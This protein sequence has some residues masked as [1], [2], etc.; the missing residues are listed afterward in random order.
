M[1]TPVLPKPTSTPP[2]AID[3][4]IEYFT[5]RGLCQECYHPVHSVGM[6]R[7]SWIHTLT[8]NYTCPPGTAGSVVKE[9]LTQGGIEYELNLASEQGYEDGSK[10]GFDNAAFDEGADKGREEMYG[11]AEEAIDEELNALFA[12]IERDDVEL[13]PD[14][15]RQAI[16]I[17]LNRVCP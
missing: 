11:E 3:I 16:D 1:S 4:A 13:T 8:G 2:S 9:V 6:G 10:N 12:Q 5:D 15:V 14:L 17:A 7:Y